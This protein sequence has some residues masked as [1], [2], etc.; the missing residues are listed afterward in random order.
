MVSI[1][2]LSPLLIIVTFVLEIME[3]DASYVSPEKSG[4]GVSRHGIYVC[5]VAGAIDR[6]VG[7]DIGLR[8]LLEVSD[9]RFREQCKALCGYCG[10][11]LVEN[12]VLLENVSMSKIWRELV[13]AYHRATPVLTLY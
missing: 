2:S 6:V 8:S 5:A 7:L 12:E 11:F 9:R 13:T 10:H 3:M 4:I 1:R